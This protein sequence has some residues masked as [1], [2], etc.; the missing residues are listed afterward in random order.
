MRKRARV[1]NGLFL[2]A[3]PGHKL[4]LLR[5]KSRIQLWADSFPVVFL[6]EFWYYLI[7]YI[8][9]IRKKSILFT[10]NKHCGQIE[11]VQSR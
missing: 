5:G 1:L 10:I 8:R 11:D 3:M 6:M 7:N 2:V 9:R 4:L